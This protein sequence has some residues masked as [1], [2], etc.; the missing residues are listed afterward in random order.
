MTGLVRHWRFVLRML[1]ALAIGAGCTPAQA[2]P[3]AVPGT[4]VTSAVVSMNDALTFTPA[5]VTLRTGGTVTWQNSGQIVH[6]ATD[7][8]AATPRGAR[9]ATTLPDGASTWDSGPV[10]PGQSWSYTF[11]QPGD[12][13]Y[14][15]LPHLSTMVGRIHVIA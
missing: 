13:T 15:C 4:P 10:G 11:T 12:Y 6:T 1:P 3:T 8:P 9:T 14:V 7:D 2:P 5:D